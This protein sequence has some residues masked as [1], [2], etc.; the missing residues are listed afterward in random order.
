MTEQRYK[1]VLAVIGDDRTVT[2]VARDWDV[3]RQ[4]LHE[5][6]RRYEEEG[7]EG[8][9]NRSHR[10]AHCPHQ[11][12]PEVEVQL[13]EMRRARPY[14]G[15][16]RLALEL[17]RKGIQPAPSKSAVHRSMSRAGVTD[18]ERRLRCASHRSLANWFKGLVRS[19]RPDA[20]SSDRVDLDSEANEPDDTGLWKSACKPHVDRMPMPLIRPNS[21]ERLRKR[22]S[23]DQQLAKQSNVQPAGSTPRH[24]QTV[25]ALQRFAGN[26]AVSGLLDELHVP[27]SRQLLLS[28]QRDKQSDLL[29][30]LWSAGNKAAFFE[31]LRHGAGGSADARRFVDSNLT[32][33]NL[34]L[35]SSII[36][37]GP[38]AS[39]PIEARV[40][41]EMKNWPDSGGKGRVFQMLRDLHGAAGRNHSLTKTLDRVF[42]DGSDDLKLAKLLAAYGPEASWPSPLQERRRPDE[43]AVTS[44]PGELISFSAVFL[45]LDQNGNVMD[46]YH[47]I[48]FVATG[49][50]FVGSSARTRA[51]I[52]GL[53]APDVKF[54]IDKGWDGKRPVEVSMEIRRQTD[55]GLTQ[56]FNWSFTKKRAVP[57][58]IKQIE[59]EMDRPA[60]ADYTYRLGP[61]KS[62][63]EPF[64]H[65]TIL[66]RFQLVDFNLQLSDLEPSF[67][68]S[69]PSIAGRSDIH[70]FFFEGPTAFGTFVVEPGNQFVDRWEPERPDPGDLSAALVSPKNV[71]EEQ[72]QT[73]EAEPGIVLGKYFV[74]T[75]LT[76][77]GTRLVSKRRLP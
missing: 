32:G 66:E 42:I 11:M 51:D 1:A 7:F 69:H 39:W 2:E 47:R 17:A 25:L 53:F 70:Q 34:W 60:P 50:E 72:I 37:H 12:P 18:P 44:A 41:R 15:A 16:R 73:F 3:T 30:Q 77:A 5:L 6:L 65:E 35:A 43:L 36:A 52:P 64:L 9:A 46:D 40:E 76:S 10:P 45:M 8:L 48:V 26:S 19:R 67:L 68:R 57:S 31:Q 49:G 63:T 4:T 71:M 75:T 33:D 20:L 28:V 14:L 61:A 59:A 62:G 38:E 54:K 27:R 24:E 55:N 29:D 74:R 56:R 23:G 58:T 21:P 13:L 22:V